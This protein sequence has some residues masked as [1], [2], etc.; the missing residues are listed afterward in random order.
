MKLSYEIL[1]IISFLS[2][3]ITAIFQVEKQNLTKDI[4]MSNPNGNGI[5]PNSY[6]DCIQPQNATNGICCYV[7]IN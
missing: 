4:C 7:N 1:F 3:E 6:S 2:K 5:K